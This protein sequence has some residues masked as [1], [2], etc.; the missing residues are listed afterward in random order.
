MPLGYV[1]SWIAWGFCGSSESMCHRVVGVEKWNRELTDAIRS[2]NRFRDLSLA[3][4]EKPSSALAFRSL[5]SLSVNYTLLSW[6]Q[7]WLLSRLS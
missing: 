3:D 2:G 7:V 1:S 6:E 4:E 5:R